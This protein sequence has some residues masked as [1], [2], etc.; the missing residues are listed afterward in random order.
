MIVL[1]CD[2]LPGTS[3]LATGENKSKFALTALKS[4]NN[5]TTVLEEIPEVD[6]KNLLHFIYKIK[7]DYLAFDN[8]QEVAPNTKE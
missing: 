4:E 5:N 3:S 8:L 2:I 6:Y 1:G 7:P